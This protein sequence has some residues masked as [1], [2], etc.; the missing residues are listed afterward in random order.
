MFA[1]R[2]QQRLQRYRW[3]WD[4]VW[5]CQHSVWPHPGIGEYTRDKTIQYSENYK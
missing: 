4:Q 2:S 1:E 5:F 3:S